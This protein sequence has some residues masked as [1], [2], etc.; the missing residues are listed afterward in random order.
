MLRKSFLLGLISFGV[1]SCLQ[2]QEPNKAAQ[3]SKNKLTKFVVNAIKNKLEESDKHKLNNPDWLGE[4]EAMHCGS[5]MF[6]NFLQK[7][8]PKTNNSIKN[9]PWVDGLEDTWEQLS[10][11]ECY[12]N[13]KER[14]RYAI[15]KAA[16][17]DL[18]KIELVLR[19][20]GM[21]AIRSF[22]SQLAAN[23]QSISK[24]MPK[25]LVLDDEYTKCDYKRYH[26]PSIGEQAGFMYCNTKLSYDQFIKMINK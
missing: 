3:N 6:G 22:M 20:E 14:M 23:G 7:M 17:H 15:T 9:K 2:A 1:L 5:K 13:A 16:E 12:G 21:T 8:F 25:E 24:D 18:V 10:N 19:K 11:A 26:S 4:I